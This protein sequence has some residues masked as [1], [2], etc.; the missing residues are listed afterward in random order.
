MEDINYP[1][2]FFR[3]ISTPDFICNGVVVAAAFQFDKEEREDGYR[4]LSINWNDDE[5][6][7][8]VLFNQRRENGKIHFK[9]GAV[10][11]DLAFTKHVLKAHID[12]QEFAFERREVEGNKY[13]GNL[14]I[15]ANVPKSIQQLVT[16]GLALV[17]RNNIIRNPNSE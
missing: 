4:E 8:E 15:K 1:Q 13:H 12:S 9:V 6:S 10:K 11:M 14:L 2:D 7:I 16:N 5:H 3:G 17:A